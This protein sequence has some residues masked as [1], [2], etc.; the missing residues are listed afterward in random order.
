MDERNQLPKKAFCDFA[1]IAEV[2]KVVRL[3]GRRQ[4]LNYA[5]FSAL[6]RRDLSRFKIAST[7]LFTHEPDR[8]AALL[9]A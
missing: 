9:I 7:F 4:K 2:K 3:L 6:T 1:Q 5:E 8:L